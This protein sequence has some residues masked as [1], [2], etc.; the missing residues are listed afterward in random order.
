VILKSRFFVVGKGERERKGGDGG[1]LAEEEV[2]RARGRT[3]VL[4]M[5]TLTRTPSP[6]KQAFYRPNTVG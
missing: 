6:R 3:L 1:R 4:A 2:T 5:Y